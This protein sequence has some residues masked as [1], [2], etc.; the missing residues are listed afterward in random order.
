MKRT[1]SGSFAPPGWPA[2]AAEPD[3]APGGDG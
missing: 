1:A 2:R 3:F